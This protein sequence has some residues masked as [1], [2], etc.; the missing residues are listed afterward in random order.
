MSW[1]LWSYCG[2]AVG[3][4][5][6]VAGILSWIGRNRYW[7]RWYDQPQMPFWMRR[8]GLVWIPLGIAAIGLSLAVHP[9]PSDVVR[10]CMGL[11]FSLGGG[12]SFLIAWYGPAWAKPRWLRERDALRPPADDVDPDHFMF[13]TMNSCT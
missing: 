11:V 10:T 6:I 4:A 1:T 2:V 13:W 9:A 12:A 7:L 3:V 8:V 5:T